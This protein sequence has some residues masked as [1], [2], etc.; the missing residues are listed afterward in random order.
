[1]NIALVIPSLLVG[2]AEVFIVRLAN[3][4]A[5]RN[6]RVFLIHLNP[7]LRSTLLEERISD[8]V[9]VVPFRYKLSRPQTIRWKILYMTTEWNASLYAEVL[10][11][12]NKFKAQC[13][14]NFLGDFCLK[15]Q[16]DVINSHLLITDWSVAHY[17]WKKPRTQK[18]VVSMHGCYNSAELG[19]RPFLIRVDKDRAN[20]LG[21]ADRIV[22]L[23]PKNAIPLRGIKL[24]N[25]PV[26]IP[27]GFEKQANLPRK[28]ELIQ[29]GPL[30]F[31]LV[32]RA[33]ARKG[34]EEA[35]R[36]ATQLTA[37][38]IECKLILVGGGV[39]QQQLQDTYGHLPFVQ[40]A[41]ATAQ[42]LSWVQ[43]CDVGLFPSYIE[44][45]SYPNTVIEYLACG[46]PV[47]GTDI[48]E[49][50]N[51]MSAPDGQL[52]GKLLDFDPKGISVTQLTACLREYDKNR[53]LL[54]EHGKL[55]ELAFEKFDMELCAAAYENAYQ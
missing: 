20:V 33:I 32:S 37:E 44:S 45:E 19:T 22:L 14:A 3:R 50:R 51:M 34:W 4:L 23:T 17:F 18:F 11:R 26:Y 53:P 8:Q 40:F 55:A 27:L 49:V 9:T 36:A 25:E 42:V 16:I 43:Q 38:G 35:I 21:T 52:A 41:G 46:K 12:R 39:Y 5:Q 30:T 24:K 15:N 6:H 47:I 48:G 2:G 13:F 28:D 7:D 54:A 10:F 31:A 29:H 1:M